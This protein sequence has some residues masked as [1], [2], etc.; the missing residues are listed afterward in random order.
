MH[1]FSHGYIEK[2]MHCAF[3]CILMMLR[4]LRKRK[5]RFFVWV[6]R[7]RQISRSE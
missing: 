6:F 2:M 1:G 4:A 5:F 3:G 7:H